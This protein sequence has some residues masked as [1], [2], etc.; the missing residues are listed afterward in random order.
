MEYSNAEPRLS[1]YLHAKACKNGTPLAGTF[2]ITPRCNFDCKMC[3]VHLSAAEQQKRGRELSADE[4]LG[5]A[6]AARSRG[7][8]FLLITGGEPLIRP[9]FKYLLSELKKM[10]ILVS[11]NSN[12]SLIDRDWLDFFKHEPPF[13]FN[14]T[15]YG[16]E[17]ATYERLCGRPAFDKVTQN[18][19]SLKELGIDV[20]INASLTQYNAADLARI[21][22]IAEELNAPIQ[23]ATYMFPPIR[24]NEDMIGQNDRFT[25]EESARYAVSWDKL[26]FDREQF[27]KRAE[28]MRNGLSLPREDACEGTPGE[29][30]SC[31]AGRSTFWINW[32]GDM[33][34]CGMMTFPA[35]SVPELGFDAAWE[36]IKAEASEIRLPHEC[37]VCEMKHACSVC[38]AMCVTETGHFDYKPV[39]L[40]DMTRETIRLTLM[41]AEHED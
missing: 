19:R 21:H 6:D 5:I 13:R 39:Y 26:R 32:K 33:T 41:E 31:R 1:M 18:I 16:G 35:V 14:I 27:C 9:D 38:A 11:V 34:P 4:W 12:G 8:L 23:V 25:A 30:I 36:K 17:N 7:M 15:L 40:C 3:Y 29:K 22:A 2:E 20:K 24:R 37:S 28:A 10:G